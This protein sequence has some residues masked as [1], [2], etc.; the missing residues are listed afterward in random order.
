[1]ITWSTGLLLGLSLVLTDADAKSVPKAGQSKAGEESEL[2]LVIELRDGSRL[3]GSPSI[4]SIPLQTSFAKIDLPLKMVDTIE[5]AEDRERVK[6]SCANGDLLQGVLNLSSFTLTT[7]FGKVS[8]VLKDI[9]RISGRPVGTT[10]GRVLYYPFD[11]DEGS[12]VTDR[13]GNGYHGNVHGAV[14]TKDGAIG[15]AMSFDGQASIDMGNLSCVENRPALSFGAWIYPTG[16]GLQGVM[17][18]T[19]AGDEVF[20]LD[21]YVR[22]ELSKFLCCAVPLGRSEERGIE[23]SGYLKMNS[24]QHLMGT[25]DGT[26]TKAYYNGVLVGQTAVFSRKP[27]NSNGAKAAIGDVAFGRGWGFHGKIDEVMVFDRALSA[28]EVRSLYQLRKDNEASDSN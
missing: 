11:K 18:K 14:W 27:T 12:I 20:Y 6:V 1:M 15:G 24:W 21:I 10:Q 4:T 5:F 13:S 26:Q 23:V 28:S 25:Y 22:P 17:G 9:A 16:V 7:S 19:I 3:I 2:Q 8:V